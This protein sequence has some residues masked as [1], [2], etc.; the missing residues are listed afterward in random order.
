MVRLAPLLPWLR[1]NPDVFILLPHDGTAG[2]VN[3]E[4]R[5]RAV[6]GVVM[7]VAVLV[8]VMVVGVVM[9]VVMVVLVLVLVVAAVAVV[10]RW[11]P[12][13]WRNVDFRRGRFQRHQCAH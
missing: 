1:A 11:R 5:V 4:A 10:T 3:S 7:V 12:W 6:V 13:R 2:G 9:V 8:S